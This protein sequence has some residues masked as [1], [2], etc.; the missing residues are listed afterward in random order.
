MGEDVIRVAA[1]IIAI[2]AAIMGD[3]QFLTGSILV[4]DTDEPGFWLR[5]HDR[6]L[7][8]WSFVAF[9]HVVVLAIAGLA[10]FLPTAS[11]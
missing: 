11:S 10:V 5:R 4:R 8:F 3:R 6:P 2:M 1:L 9:F 7:A